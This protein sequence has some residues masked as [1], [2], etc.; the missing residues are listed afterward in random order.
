MAVGLGNTEAMLER[1]MSLA[2][3]LWWSC[4]SIFPLIYMMNKLN[5]TENCC[6]WRMWR[7]WLSCVVS[8]SPLSWWSRVS[9]EGSRVP[10]TDSRI[11]L[12]EEKVTLEEGESMLLMRWWQVSSEKAWN[13]NFIHFTGGDN[14]VL[15]EWV[16]WLEWGPGKKHGLIL[17]KSYTSLWSK[18]GISQIP[19]GFNFFKSRFWE[20]APCQEPILQWSKF[21]Q[22]F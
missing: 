2:N 20:T 3:G 11:H 18:G 10:T 15:E 17:P 19:V 13:V 9:R 14:R 4:V 22:E 12:H 1:W 7:V 8:V 5:Y 21:Q 16:H 6:H